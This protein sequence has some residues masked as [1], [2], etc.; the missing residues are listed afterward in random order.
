MSCKLT[1]IVAFIRLY[2]LLKNN[3]NDQTVNCNY[4]HDIQQ[5]F[6]YYFLIFQFNVIYFQLDVNPYECTK[7]DKACQHVD[8]RM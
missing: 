4:L 7:C 8:I 6:N 2:L 1:N 5:S 3:I